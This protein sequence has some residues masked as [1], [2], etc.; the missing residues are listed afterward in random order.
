MRAEGLVKTFPG[1]VV[2]L[3][4]VGFRVGRGEVVA[5][6]GANGSGKTT[7]LHILFGILAADRGEAELLGLRPRAETRALR[8]RT[9]FAGQDAALDPETTG[10]ETLRLFYAL[11]GLPHRERGPRLTRL[12]DAYGL[13]DYCDRRIAT[14]SGGQRRR[15]HLALAVVHDPPLLLLDEPTTGLDPEGR[16]AFWRLAARWREAGRTVLAATHDLEAVAGHCDRALILARGRLVADAPPAALIAEQG[17]ARAVFTLAA[18]PPSPEARTELERTL[19]ELPGVLDVG[20]D[21]PTLTLWRDRHP[22]GTD[23]ALSLLS[24][25]GVRFLAYERHEP[26]LA[27]AYL[28]LTGTAWAPREA[29]PGPAS[30]G[31]RT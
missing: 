11:R 12:A 9:G 22:E 7:L 8:S 2:A 3:D 30:R 17:R 5:V 31:R 20:L 1:G 21:G 13:S 29:R 23:P 19:A 27:S 6:V 16:A 15:L 25:R 26:D 18:A 14:Y 28:R 24:D 4:G 10:W